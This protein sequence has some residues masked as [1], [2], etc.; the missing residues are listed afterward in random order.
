[1][2]LQDGTGTDGMDDADEGTSDVASATAGEP[3]VAA[4]MDTVVAKMIALN[5]S[6]GNAGVDVDDV[7][8]AERSAAATTDQSRMTAVAT[9]G[10]S[11]G[12]ASGDGGDDTAP[13]GN[14]QA[15]SKSVST[16]GAAVA[17]GGQLQEGAGTEGNAGD[18]KQGTIVASA[19][20]V[21]ESEP[22]ATATGNDKPGTAMALVSPAR[23]GESEATA[24]GKPGTVMVTASPAQE[25]ASKGTAA[26]A[27]IDT[28]MGGPLEPA[29]AA[30]GA[31]QEGAR[32]AVE[33]VSAP[34]KNL[35]MPLL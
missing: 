23:E 30:G 6:D 12:Q 33:P 14:S 2:V 9:P 22:Q 17:P 1:M 8:Q 18:G 4:S 21:Q 13:A 31:G 15:H 25:D 7:H 34:K 20:P 28:T 19:S 11:V 27:A 3:K 10:D 16:G 35:D 24:A 29:A 5:G 32:A 26:G